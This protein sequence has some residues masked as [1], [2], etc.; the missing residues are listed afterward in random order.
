MQLSVQMSIVDSVFETFF[1]CNFMN[2]AIHLQF[3]LYGH[4]KKY[5]TS[6]KEVKAVALHVEQNVEMSEK[7]VSEKHRLLNKV[8]RKL[9]ESLRWRSLTALPFFIGINVQPLKTQSKEF[10]STDAL[11]S[12]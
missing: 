4:F 6:E 7:A 3:E 8:S 2:H 9:S 11:R 5:E 12:Q 1:Y 10:F